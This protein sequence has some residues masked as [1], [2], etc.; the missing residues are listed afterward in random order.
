MAEFEIPLLSETTLAIE[1]SFSRLDITELADSESID[2]MMNIKKNSRPWVR[3]NWNNG[4]L[5]HA[6]C[7]R[8]FENDGPEAILKQY[9]L[10]HSVIR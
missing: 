9:S 5:L 1:S 10:L 7:E 6:D 2:D 4:L 3:F 8:D